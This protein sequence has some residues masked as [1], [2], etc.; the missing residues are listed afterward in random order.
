MA[1][2]TVAQLKEVVD[3]LEAD[4]RSSSQQL[5]DIQNVQ[6]RDFPVALD[7]RNA[8]GDLL[9]VRGDTL[10]EVERTL[11]DYFGDG[12]TLVM[13]QSF[14]YA[15]RGT[16]G[17][18][19]S[20]DEALDKPDGTFSV[21]SDEALAYSVVKQRK[22]A[23]A[24]GGGRPSGRSSA[25]AYDDDGDF[26]TWWDGACPSCGST[27]FYDNRDD[28]GPQG[29]RPHFKCKDCDNAAWPPDDRPKSGGGRRSRRSD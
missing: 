13:L 8:Q 6:R 3:A 28:L 24:K 15:F 11:T 22:A 12:A 25:A 27:N 18:G 2:V 20:V 29:K 5:A 1:D 16:V 4:L 17:A 14:N 19:G 10:D 9:H 21:D 26:P 7:L 23:P